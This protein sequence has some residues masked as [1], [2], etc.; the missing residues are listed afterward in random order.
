MAWEVR[1]RCTQ[2]GASG[3]RLIKTQLAKGE[4]VK[5]AEEWS[6]QAFSRRGEKVNLLMDVGECSAQRKPVSFKKPHEPRS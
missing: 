1:G 4:A 5:H 6:I 3:L 2:I